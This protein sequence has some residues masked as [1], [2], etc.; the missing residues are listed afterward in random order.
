MLNFV[1]FIGVD[2]KQQLRKTIDKARFFSIQMD[3]S[4]DSGN[5]DEEL[6]MVMEVQQME[7]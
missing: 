3:S 1:K 6:F 2:L 7:R 5:I 4:T